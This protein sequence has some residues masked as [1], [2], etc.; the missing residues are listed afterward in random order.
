V[1]PIIHNGR[2][3]SLAHLEPMIRRE[4]LIGVIFRN[5]CYTEAFDAALH[6][7]D[8]IVLHDGPQWPRVFSEN[9]HRLSASL[10]NLVAKLPSQRVHQT[11]EQR[12]YVYEANVELET[13]P[14]QIYFM[15]QRAHNEKGVDLRLTI[16]SAYPAHG[17][18]ALRKRP[19]NIRFSILA[20]KV[21]M[22]QPIRFS[23]R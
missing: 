3:V 12:N 5:H 8:Q 16:E 10:P 14:Y 7:R 15:V 19:N 1:K 6:T 20:Y 9:R 11:T 17:T 23:A 4:L 21:L 18:H 2:V 13:A 22:G